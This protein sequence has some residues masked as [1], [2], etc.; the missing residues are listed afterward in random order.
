MTGGNDALK[1]LLSILYCG[2]SFKAKFEFVIV[3]L[4]SSHNSSAENYH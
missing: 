2:W 3:H 4:C 1:M